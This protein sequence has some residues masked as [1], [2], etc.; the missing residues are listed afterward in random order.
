M[1]ESQA[2]VGNQVLFNWY[3]ALWCPGQWLTEYSKVVV[4][5]G[6]PGQMNLQEMNLWISVE[7]CSD[8]FSRILILCYVA[9]VKRNMWTVEFS[10]D[11]NRHESQSDL[12]DHIPHCALC[13]AAKDQNPI[14][15]NGSLR[16]VAQASCS[17]DYSKQPL[18]L[19]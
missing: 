1:I 8:Q 3:Q 12:L 13:S 6:D 18:H 10:H 15:A 14:Q 7:H 19:I 11:L 4:F 17:L 2:W 9:S 16:D 5:W